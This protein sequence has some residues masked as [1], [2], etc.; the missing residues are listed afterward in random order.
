MIYTKGKT[1]HLL[2]LLFTAVA[3][4]LSLSSPC[5][6]ESEKDDGKGPKKDISKEE[7]FAYIKERCTID[8]DNAETKDNVFLEG[9]MLITE[10][11]AYDGNYRHRRYA[12][13]EKLNP[14]SPSPGVWPSTNGIKFGLIANSVSYATSDEKPHVKYIVERLKDNYKLEQIYNYGYFQCESE[15]AAKQVA[16]ALKHLIK[17]CGGKVPKD[18]FD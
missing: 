13:L 2:L 6:S 18:L 3:L 7:T 17:L 8:N 15:T 11:K 9:C 10:T 16:R 14:E 5:F 4:T 12:S 1:L